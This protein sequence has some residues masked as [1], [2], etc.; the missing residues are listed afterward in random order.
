MRRAGETGPRSRAERGW[1]AGTDG[2]D[3]YVFR[4]I[5]GG[6]SWEE[7]RTAVPKGLINVQDL[8]FLDQTRGW[9][10]TWH[11]NDGGTYLFSTVNGGKSWAPEANL[12]FQGKGNWAEIVRFIDERRGFVFVEA[13]ERGLSYTTDGGAH[14]EKQAI[15]RFLG[16]CQVFEGDLLCSCGPGFGLLTVHPQ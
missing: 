7:S 16:D 3:L 13:P 15:R 6:I 14:W 5:D 11:V 1:L 8:F 12:S 4:T 9:L 10:I 2:K